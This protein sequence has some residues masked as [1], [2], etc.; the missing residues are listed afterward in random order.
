MCAIQAWEIPSSRADDVLA[1]SRRRAVG[2]DGLLSVA[3]RGRPAGAGGVRPR[4]RSAPD[5]LLGARSGR[6]AAARRPRPQV[7]GDNHAAAPASAR[8]RGLAPGPRPR[9]LPTAA[10]ARR[11]RPPNIL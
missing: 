10:G 6:P 11:L 3:G 5:D 1:R 8:H 9:R 2:A 7:C 4:P